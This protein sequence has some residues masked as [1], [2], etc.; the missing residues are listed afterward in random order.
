MGL[1]F[2]RFF[3]Y[4]FAYRKFS[5]LLHSFDVVSKNQMVT[6]HEELLYNSLSL[7]YI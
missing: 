6:L 1:N 3:F 5:F 7:L 2:E 4:Q